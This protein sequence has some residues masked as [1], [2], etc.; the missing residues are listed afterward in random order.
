MENMFRLDNLD[1][2]SDSGESE[3]D[4]N[5]TRS[6]YEL[7]TIKPA[8]VRSVLESFKNNES[9]TPKELR[10]LRTLINKAHA[11]V[12][13]IVSNCTLFKEILQKIGKTG[14]ECILKEKT[15]SGSLLDLYQE[16]EYKSKV[17]P[18]FLTIFNEFG[19]NE[20][21]RKLEAEV[22]E[23]RREGIERRKREKNQKNRK[24]KHLKARIDKQ[25]RPYTESNLISSQSTPYSP[26]QPSPRFE[27]PLEWDIQNELQSAFYPVSSPYT[28]ISHDSGQSTRP[29]SRSASSANL[30]PFYQEDDFTS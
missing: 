20:E 25:K 11:P 4:D 10:E 26:P 5:P 9:F 28:E 2:S 3:V 13:A 17:S 27:I 24:K 15:Y 12:V 16:I 14:W 18:K 22:E 21:I 8:R 19:L 30:N 23:V 1:S 29:S 6:I 7:R